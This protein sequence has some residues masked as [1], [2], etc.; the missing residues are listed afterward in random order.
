MACGILDGRNCKRNI[1]R[2]AV[3][4][5]PD[6]FEMINAL[7]SPEPLKNHCFLVLAI[8]GNN[9]HNALADS[10]FSRVAEQPLRTF[11]PTGDHTIQVLAD[12]GIVRGTYDSSQQTGRSFGLFFFFFDIIKNKKNKKQPQHPFVSE[13]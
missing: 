3:L 10:L 2:R 12:D 7:T 1:K 9:E 4:A 5:Y 8:S 6:S 13:Y 11:I